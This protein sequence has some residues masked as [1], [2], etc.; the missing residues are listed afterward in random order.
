LIYSS[1]HIF[2]LCHC[3]TAVDEASDHV[4]IEPMSE[5]KQVFGGTLRIAGEQL[6]RFALL[7]GETVFRH[8]S[9]T[10]ISFFAGCLN[11]FAAISMASR[12][13]NA[14]ISPTHSRLAVRPCR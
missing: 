1:L 12:W 7:R 2:A 3:K 4:A 9:C 6:Q 11:S 8:H 13:S 5:D 14:S 10:A